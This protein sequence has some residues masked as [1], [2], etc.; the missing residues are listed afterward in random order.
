VAISTTFAVN[1]PGLLVT[2]Y[3]TS[4]SP[5]CVHDTL[6]PREIPVTTAETSV[7]AEGGG[8]P[9]AVT[10]FEGVDAADEPTVFDATTVKV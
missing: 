1:P 6:A 5:N 4:E 7:T 2:V 10:E 9:I 8:S 3:V